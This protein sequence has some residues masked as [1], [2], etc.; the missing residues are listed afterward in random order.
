MHSAL[1]LESFADCRMV[2]VTVPLRGHQAV[3]AD[4]VLRQL[5]PPLLEIQFPT[6]DLPLD[7]IEPTEKWR[8]TFDKGVAFLTAWATLGQMISPNLVQLTITHSETNN[9]A[10][11]DHRVD[12]EIYLRYWQGGESRQNLKSLRTRVNLSGYGIS[13]QTETSLPPNCL[14]EFELTLPGTVLETVRCVG[15]VIRA[16]GKKQGCFETAFEMANISREDME[17]VIHYCMTEQFKKMQNKTRILAATLNQVSDNS[18]NG[19]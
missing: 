1:M 19:D 6:L 15:R 5:S 7:R 12:T 16:V 18:L 13:F 11:R 4:G 3:H 8:I 9:H 10:R 17:K 14:V 2:N